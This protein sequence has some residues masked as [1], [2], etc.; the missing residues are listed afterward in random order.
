MRL[1]IISDLHVPYHHSDSF[2]FLEAIKEKYDPPQVIC[3]GDEIDWHSISFHDSDPELFSASHELEQSIEK[4]STLYKMFPKMKILESNHGSLV[5][6]KQK[7][8]GLP[9]S[10]F[11]DYR[12][13]LEAPRGWSW[14]NELLINY[15]GTPYY[16]HHGLNKDCLKVAQQRGVNFIQGHHHTEFC[17]KYFNTGRKILFGMTV[18][19]LINR[20]SLAFAYAKNNVLPQM[21]GCGIIIDGQPKL[22]PLVENKNGRW[23]GKIY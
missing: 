13:I 18:G 10:V 5:Y 2:R 14:H 3:I 8:H 21:L 12:D 9:R 23:N 6:R 19:C 1:L 17:I 7:F 22:L 20:N 16:F 4:L 15:K 11:K